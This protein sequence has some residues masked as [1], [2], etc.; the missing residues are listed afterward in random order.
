MYKRPVAIVPADNTPIETT[1]VEEETEEI[2][3]VADDLTI[4]DLAD[5]VRKSKKLVQQIIQQ[6]ENQSLNIKYNEI[7]EH[8]EQL[9]L[10]FMEKDNKMKTMKDQVAKDQSKIMTEIQSR[11]QHVQFLTCESGPLNY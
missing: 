2:T 5:E 7:K 4:N 8:I 9:K 6:N 10:N 3:K 11:V 1:Q